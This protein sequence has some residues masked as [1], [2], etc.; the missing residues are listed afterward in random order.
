[1]P[2]KW[3]TSDKSGTGNVN[4][5][6]TYVQAITQVGDTVFTG[7]DFAYLESAAG[8]HVDQSYLAGFNVNTGELVQTF[9]PKFNG[10]IKSLEALPNNKLA[11]V[12]NSPRLTAKGARFCGA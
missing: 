11:V 1:M 3:R 10:Q 5:M 7:G 9:K 8:A 6:N 12:V 2:W 4:E